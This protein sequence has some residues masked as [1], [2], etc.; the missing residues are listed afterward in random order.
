MSLQVTKTN[1]AD[2]TTAELLQWFNENSGED[3]VKRFSDRASAERRVT[4]LLEKGAVATEPTPATP[5][6][7]TK[8]KGKKGKSAPKA[9]KEK[10]APKAKK[11]RAS[12]EQRSAAVKASWDNEAVRAARS[13]RHNVRVDGTLYESVLKAFVALRLDVKAHQR[14]RRELVAKGKTEFNGHKFVLAPKEE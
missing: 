1:L 8:A 7:A 9:K 13:A 14:L 6:P 4:A 12:P 2:F 5:A 11:E 10:G 3:P